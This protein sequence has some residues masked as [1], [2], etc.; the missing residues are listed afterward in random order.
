M[1]GQEQSHSLYKKHRLPEELLVEVADTSRKP[2]P[3]RRLWVLD[4]CCGTESW[5]EKVCE[6]RGWGYLGV[7]IVGVTKQYSSYQAR[8]VADLSKLK[9]VDLMRVAYNLCGLLPCDLVL[10]WSS[11]PCDTYRCPHWLLIYLHKLCGSRV[12]A[13]KGLHRVWTSVTKEPTS[14]MGDMI[15]NGGNSVYQLVPTIGLCA[16]LL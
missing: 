2:E 5:R 15:V 3:A 10:I 8:Y 16:L 4:L 9:L 7:D 6:K 14:G 12:C 1:L 11:P 13:V